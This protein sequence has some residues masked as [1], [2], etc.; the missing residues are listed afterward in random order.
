MISELIS[1]HEVCARFPSQWVA[2]VELDFADDEARDVVIALVAGTGTRDEAIRQAKPLRGTFASL[3]TFFTGGPA[4][5]PA[6][7]LFVHVS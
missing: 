1:W 2:L 6:V 5:T 7:P 4:A 3:G